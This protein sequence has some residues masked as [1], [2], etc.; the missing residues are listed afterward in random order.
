VQHSV[1][2]EQP[3]EEIEEVGCSAIQ[4]VDALLAL[5]EQLLKIAPLP[6]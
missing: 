2:K 4:Q 3:V 6:S 1:F 5:S